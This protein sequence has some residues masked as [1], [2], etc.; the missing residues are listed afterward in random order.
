LFKIKGAKNTVLKNLKKG[1]MYLLLQLIK[2]KNYEKDF[3][4]FGKE[5]KKQARFQG[6]N[7]ICQ[8]SR[9]T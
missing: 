9:C 1:I 3:S 2:T 6:K 7:G 8:W 4:A 5:T